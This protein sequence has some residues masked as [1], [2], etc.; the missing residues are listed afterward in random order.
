MNGLEQINY[1]PIY[2]L[3]TKTNPSLEVLKLTIV[4]IEVP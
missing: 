3:A 4:G 1:I 2:I